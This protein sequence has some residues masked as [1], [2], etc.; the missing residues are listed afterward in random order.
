MGKGLEAIKGTLAAFAITAHDTLLPNSM[1]ALM[2][3][4]DEHGAGLPPPPRVVVAEKPPV[5][6]EDEITPFDQSTLE[7]GDQEAVPVVTWNISEK[8]RLE[9]GPDAILGV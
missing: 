6:D 2:R 8:D 7:I 5:I 1:S 3:H 9:Y 4:P